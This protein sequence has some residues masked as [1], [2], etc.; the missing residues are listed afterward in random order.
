MVLEL[1]LEQCRRFYSAL[2]AA[3]LGESSF[4]TLSDGKAVS[5]LS[6]PSQVQIVIEEQAK[7]GA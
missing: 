5:F 6:H 2:I 3:T 4:H 7:L 1:S